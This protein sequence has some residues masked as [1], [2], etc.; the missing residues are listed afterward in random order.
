M[1]LSYD[2]MKERANQL[3]LDTCPLLFKGTLRNFIETYSKPGVKTGDI[4][5]DLN[6][7]FYKELLEK[8][9]IFDSAVVEEGF[10]VRIDSYPK[11]E[12]YKIKS[13]IFLKQESDWKDRDVV[14][15]EENPESYER[16]EEKTENS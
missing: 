15:L 16:S 6:E 8:P 4:E 2:Q 11:T 9:S 5:K 13:K 14:D 3:N 7:I 12:C 10:C 1:D